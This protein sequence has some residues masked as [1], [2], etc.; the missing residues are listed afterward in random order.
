MNIIITLTTTLK[1]EFMKIMVSILA[2][3][4]L[5]TTACSSG[6]DGGQGNNDNLPDY[7]I[8]NSKAYNDGSVI[9][10]GDSIAR[11]EGASSDVKSLVGCMA[12]ASGG[13]IVSNMANDGA[14]TV[15]S[16]NFLNFAVSN[17]PALA[18]I[19]L[20]G[21][22][23][24]IDAFDQSIPETKTLDNIRK[25]FKSF[26]EAGTLVLH[27]GLNPPAN[28]NFPIDVDTSRLSKIKGI[29]VEE[30]VLFLENSMEGMWGNPEYMADE[31]HP[32]DKGYALLCDRVKSLLAPHF[33]IQ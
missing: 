5:T 30:G 6:S 18:V 25:I 14:T 20:G 17:K 10:F 31:V 19:S 3:I 7:N 1:G 9:L 2:A 13:K 32:N 11:G 16:M 22:D 23:A 8:K 27:I 29:A 33:T 12:L 4:A 28:P 15:D 21:N 24:I 26:T